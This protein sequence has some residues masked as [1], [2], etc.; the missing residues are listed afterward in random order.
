M[1]V[2]SKTKYSDFAQYEPFL[3]DESKSDLKKAAERHIILCHTL[4]LDEFFGL[5]NG[6]FSLLGDLQEPTVLQ[7]FWLTRFKEFCDEFT[8]SCEAL[9]I[10]DPEAVGIDNGCITISPQESALLFTREYFGL[11]SFEDAGKR[12]IGEYILARKDAFNKWVMRKNNEKKQLAKIH[13]KK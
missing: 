9:T 3:T 13:K 11:G 7:V 2:T 12:T 8:R 1:K 10:K 4:T 6:D 5:L